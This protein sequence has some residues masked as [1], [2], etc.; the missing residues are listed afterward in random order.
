VTQIAIF[1][2]ALKPVTQEIHGSWDLRIKNDLEYRRI[3][4]ISSRLVFCK[5]IIWILIRTAGSAQ[6]LSWQK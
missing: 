1:A 2:P 3:L 5:G 6:F 4:L